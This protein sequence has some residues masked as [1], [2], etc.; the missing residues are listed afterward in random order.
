ML[1]SFLIDNLSIEIYENQFIRSDFT[2]IRVYMFRLSSLTTLKIYKD[3]FKGLHSGC[4]WMKLDA[5]VLFKQ[6]VTEDIFALVHISLE[7]AI[8]LYAVGFVTKELHDLHR[9]NELK[10]F[11]ANILLKLVVSHI[12]GSVYRLVSHILGVVH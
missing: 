5:K 11:T 12:L 2:H 9:I 8:V 3:Y 10:N 1:D 6:I 4:K 7:E